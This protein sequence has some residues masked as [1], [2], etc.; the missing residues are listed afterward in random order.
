MDTT[1]SMDELAEILAEMDI[2]SMRRDFN[3]RSNLM[4]LIRNIMFK[5]SNHPR[6]VDVR[7]TLNELARR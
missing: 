3:D 2:P 1:L 4:W 5:N 7:I 6:I